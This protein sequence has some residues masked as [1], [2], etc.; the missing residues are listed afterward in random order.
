V[1][2]I[3]RDKVERAF[4]FACERHAD[5][6]RYSGD[7]FITHPVGVAQ[8]CAGMR[9]DTDT[10]CAALLH[11]TVEDT[12]A[13]LEE[14]REEFGEEIAALVDGVTK[15]TGM[16]FESRDER[17]AENYRKM[18]VAMATD[19]RVILIKLA[20]RLHNMRTLGALPKQKQTLKSHETL[21]IYAPL[22]H[23]L[24]IHAIKWEL[25]DLAFAT[26]HPRKYAEIKQLVAQQRD[27]RENY[28]TEAGEF[29][30][31]ELEEVG[32]QAEISG[33]AKHFY[34]IYTKM[35]KK[36][37]E[38]NEI[39]DLTA[40]RVIV[41]SVKDCYGAIGVIHSLWK[42]LPGRF[43]DFVAMPK[44]NMYQALHTTVIGPEGKP[45]EIQIRTEEMHKL[46]E[47]GIA[48]HVAYKEGGR[49]DPQR[50]KM[51]WLRQLVE[52]E[53][54]Q[55]PAEF[56]ES[57]KVDL[58]EDEVFV[59]TP[60]GEVKSLS[61]GS[62]PL[63]FAYAV[64]TDVG[65]SCV[66]AKVNGAIVPL[67]YQLRSGDIVEVL[68][69]KQKRAPSL[70]WLKLVRTSRARNKI[71]AWFKE[72][73]REDAERDG[74][75]GLE[76]ALKRRGVP[77]QKI[78][79][80]AL[81]ADV[82]REM[83]FRKASEFYIALGQ[84]KISNKAAVNKILQ[85]LKSGES[86][87]DDMLPAT[88][89][90][91]RARRTKDAS[92]YGIVVKGVEDVA[93]RLAKCCRPVPGDDIAGYVSLGRGIT[94]HRTDCKNVK[95]LKRAPERFVDVGW[96]GDNE[97]SYRVEIQIDAYD[98][99]RLLEDLSRTF[100]EGGINIIGA[101]CTTNHPMVKNKFVIEVG[102]T[103]QLKHCISRLRNV[104]SVFDAYR[105]TPTA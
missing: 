66:G 64:H 23:R 30:S 77:M 4:D 57:L 68:T 55:D 81:L 48:A 56:L 96:E 47:Y 20:D 11:D 97:A 49:G 22:A 32:I 90:S 13:T 9:L 46:A 76:E 53:G 85:R 7:E 80:S 61:A 89:H 93:V 87:D 99:T 12:S 82:I 70:D 65:H 60:K 27:E 1:A 88:Q 104:E 10:L 69:A 6:K 91:D 54:E 24:G 105:I 58:F 15:L 98:R 86:V 3:D 18:M 51:T 17:Q 45:L 5:Q 21:E 95:A 41:G 59:F 39:F 94:I 2:T 8:I 44:A 101:S 103:E 100:S 31:E 43:K 38:F 35:A 25:E 79:G 42:P 50:E 37:R 78:A 40:M 63:D 102:D 75:E 73:R 36:G 71:R 19:V 33:R 84:G 14:V 16:N 72:E 83:G 92:N 74:R 67:H 62:T 28:V 34:S 52:A 26:L 29:L